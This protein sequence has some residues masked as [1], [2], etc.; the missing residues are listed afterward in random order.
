MKTQFIA[1]TKI[2][3]QTLT[4]IHTV[5]V[6]NGIQYTL[7]ESGVAVLYRDNISFP[8]LPAFGGLLIRFP[9]VRTIVIGSQICINQMTDS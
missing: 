3:L 5:Q 7:A 6:L 1:K 2:S 4:S 8:Q 9:F